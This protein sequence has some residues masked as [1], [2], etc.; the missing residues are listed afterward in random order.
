VNLFD[1]HGPFEVREQNPFLPAEVTPEAARALSQKP[2]DYFCA[3]SRDDRTMAILWGLYLGDV[4][5]GDRKLGHFRDILAGERKTRP[6][7]TVVT[8]DHGEHF[9][10]H[11]LF[12]HHFS[13]REPLLHVP[14]VIHGLPDVAPAVI[15]TPVELADLMPTMLAWAGAPVPQDLAGRPLPTQ[16]GAAAPRQL[17]AE[18]DDYAGELAPGGGNLPPLIKK[19]GDSM[20]RACG[21]NDHVFGGMRAIIR[22]PSKLIWYEG[23]PPQLYD[24]LADPEEERNLAAAHPDIVAAMTAELHRQTGAPPDSEAAIDGGRLERDQVERLRALGYVTVD[25]PKAGGPGAP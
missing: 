21:P 5:E 23:Y 3:V 20:R 8:S 18:H 6:L 7:V 4:R 22:H 1:A 12:Q 13:V 24:L 9:G 17:I 14:L 16:S 10:E 2:E 25:E 11:H 19:Q 15:D